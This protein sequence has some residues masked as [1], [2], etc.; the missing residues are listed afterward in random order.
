MQ[1]Y[2]MAAVLIVL[3]ITGC[4]SPPEVKQLSV[5]QMELF[6]TAISAVSIQSEALMMTAERL[7]TEAKQRID[8]EEQ[9]T[10]SRMTALV[11]QGGLD[12]EQASE[13]TR[14]ISERSAQAILA[15]QQLDRDLALIRTKTVELNGFIAK[16]KEVHVAL[17][18]YIQSEKAGEMV[19]ND[20][21]NQPSVRALLSG[22]NE[23]M[24]RIERSQSDLTTLLG[25]L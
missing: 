3:M 10:R 6:D 2:R 8:A 19:V 9:D 14:R 7:V 21:L 4:A 23:L 11:Q 5:K 24:T 17:D 25:A 15:K 18:A 22:V 12:S 16:M 13:L 20:V 1:I